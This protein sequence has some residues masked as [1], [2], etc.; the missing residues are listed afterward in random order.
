MWYVFIPKRNIV[1]NSYLSVVLL[2]EILV[3]LFVSSWFS[4]KQVLISNY[5]IHV[6]NYMVMW[7]LIVWLFVRVLMWSNYE[8]KVVSYNGTGW[9]E[10]V[11]NI[12]AL[13][14]LYHPPPLNFVGNDYWTSTS[15]LEGGRVSCPALKSRNCKKI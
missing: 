14:S 2:F 12:P 9:V 6:E 4:W 7:L 13:V 3:A 15:I 10:A 8:N 5:S 11:F 1:F